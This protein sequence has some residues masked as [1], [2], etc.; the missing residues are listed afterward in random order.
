[1]ND[2]TEKPPSYGYKHP[3]NAGGFLSIQRAP[4]PSALRQDRHHQEA[5][6]GRS[7]MRRYDKNKNMD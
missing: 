3:L 6:T 1:M 7:G 2:I 5:E 4:E